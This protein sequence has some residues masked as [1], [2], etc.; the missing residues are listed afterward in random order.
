LS[1]G[2]RLVGSGMAGAAEP[3]PP[4]PSHRRRSYGSSKSAAWRGC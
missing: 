2:L 4:E 1:T 3:P